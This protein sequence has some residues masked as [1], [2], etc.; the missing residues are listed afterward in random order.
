MIHNTHDNLTCYVMTMGSGGLWNI[1]QIQQM[2]NITLNIFF[3][4]KKIIF[5]LFFPLSPKVTDL[6]V[7]AA[8]VESALQAV[9]RYQSLPSFLFGCPCACAKTGGSWVASEI[10]L[11][12]AE[13]HWKKN[14]TGHLLSPSSS[15]FYWHSLHT[16]VLSL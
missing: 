3:K 11:P 12:P 1:W 10:A 13:D 14:M 7:K 16:E 6:F 8:P 4:F 15:S 2:Q 9:P 5:H